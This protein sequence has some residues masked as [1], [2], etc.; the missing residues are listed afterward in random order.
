MRHQVCEKDQTTSC[1]HNGVGWIRG[2]MAL[3]LLQPEEPQA[4]NLLRD[5]WRAL[6]RSAG[7]AYRWG[8][9]DNQKTF[10]ETPQGSAVPES[11]SE[12]GQVSRFS[13]TRLSTTRTRQR[14]QTIKE[15]ESERHRGEGLPVPI[16]CP[17]AKL[18]V[19]GNAVSTDFDYGTSSL[20]SSAA[21]NSTQRRA[22]GA[23]SRGLYG[24]GDAHRCQSCCG[25]GT[26]HTEE[27]GHQR[28]AVSHQ[29][30]GQCLQEAQRGHPSETEAPLAVASAL[31]GVHPAL[32]DSAQQLQETTA[33]TTRGSQASSEG[34][35]CSTAGH[36]RTEC[37]SRDYREEQTFA[38]TPQ[39][40]RHRSG[41]HGRC[42]SRGGE[43]E[44]E[45]PIFAPKK[46]TCSWSRTWLCFPAFGHLW[47]C[48]GGYL[49]RRG[50]SSRLESEEAEICRAQLVSQGS[51]RWCPEENQLHEPTNWKSRW[52]RTEAYDYSLISDDRAASSSTLP[53]A[54][55]R[56]ITEPLLWR[57]SVEDEPDFK[58]PWRALR[59]AWMLRYQVIF[60][61]DQQLQ[62]P[63]SIL[64]WNWRCFGSSL[65]SKSHS[66]KEKKLR[67]D[68]DPC[69]ESDVKS[70]TED[71]DATS[72]MA[73]QPRHHSTPAHS[74]S[75]SEDSDL[76][77]REPTSP[78]SSA[79]A[80]E[81]LWRSVQVY[82]LHS[83]FARGRA[84]VHPVEQ[85][86]TQVRRLLGYT[87]HEVAHI[88]DI[89]PPPEDLDSVH[90]LPMLL[91]AHDDLYYGDH[92]R[93]VL[94]D[95]DLHG[96]SFESL[97][98]TDRYT[99]LI[100]SVVHRAY[101]LRIAG[102]ASYCELQDSRCLVWHRGN[103]LPAQSSNTVT[104]MHG[105]YI[106]I[107]V[108]PFEQPTIPTH[109][110]VRACKAG[111][112]RGQLVHRFQQL[113]ANDD[114]LFT[115]IDAAQP[116]QI[117]ADGDD[118]MLTQLAFKSFSSF[119][120]KQDTAT[121]TEPLLRE[122][123]IQGS[124]HQPPILERRI[125]GALHDPRQV[126]GTDALPTWTA[127][128]H[129]A[130]TAAAAVEI[131]EEG[132]VGFVDTWYLRGAHP[133]VTENTRPYRA[134]Q[135]SQHWFREI[136]DL[137]RDHIDWTIP[138]HFHWV[139]PIPRSLMT[140]DRFGHLIIH[141]DP[142]HDL[143]PN[144]VTI[145]FEGNH[146]STMTFAAVLQFNPI[147]LHA[148]RD[149][150]NLGRHCL[151]RRCALHYDQHT[152]QP[153][154][155]LRVPPGAGLEFNIGP[156]IELYHIHDDHMTGPTLQPTS[157]MTEA[158][159]E[160]AHPP[161]EAHSHFVQALHAAW[162]VLATEGPAGIENVL[163]IQTWY[164]ESGYVRHH[165]L[166]RDVVLGEDFWSWETNIIHR[167]ADF[168]IPDCD[169]D[170]H[171]VTPAPPTAANPN[172]VHVIVAQNLRE[173]ECAS[174]ATTYD[175]AIMRGQPYT[176]ALIFPNAV[177]KGEILRSTGKSFVCPP[178]MPSSTCTCWFG[179][180]Q[181]LDG[182]RFP[183]RNGFSFIVIVHRAIP[184]NFWE[185]DYDGTTEHT[186]VSLLQIKTQLRRGE[187]QI[188][189][190]VAHT[191]QP[192]P[193]SDKTQSID[194]HA[195]ILAF[196][197]FDAH[198]FLPTF[199][200][201]GVPEG[202][203]AYPWLTTWWDY[204][205]HGQ[206]L[207]I[208]YDGSA[209][210]Q[211]SGGSVSAAAAA[212]LRIGTEWVFAGAIATPLPCAQD[213]YA[214]EHFASA[215]SMKLCYDILKI[216]EVIGTPMPEVHFCLDSLTVGHQTAGLWSCFR[217]PTLG[218]A[219]RNI[220]RL[221]ETRFNPTIAHW[222]VRGHSGHPGNELVDLLANQAHE[223][224]PDSSAAWLASISKA[225]FRS[226]SDWFWILFDAEFL[227]YW[228]WHSLRFPMPTTAPSSKLLG[229][230]GRHMEAEKDD[231]GLQ[232]HL[233]LATCNVLSL[234]G[235]RDDTE[236]GIQGPARQEMLLQQLHEE[237]ITI[238][239]LQETRL[240]KLH[241][242]HAEKYFLFRA[243][244]TDKGQCGILVGISK[245]LTFASTTSGPPRQ[246]KFKEEHIS[247]V[248]QSPRLLIL[249]VS[250]PALRCILVAGHAPHSGNSVEELHQWWESVTDA[251][252]Q[253][254]ASWP[255]LLLAD[256]NAV[257][258]H[259]TTSAIGSHQ[260]GPHEI[261]SEA[262]EAFIHR[263]Q[264]WLP[265][266]FEEHQQGPGDTW[267]HSSGKTRRIDYV[268][269]PCI[270]PTTECRAWISDVIDPSIT[271]TD[272][273]AACV[274]VRFQGQLRSPHTRRLHD[275]LVIAD[276]KAVDL[277]SLQDSEVVAPQLDVH[278]HAALL[279]QMIVDAVAPQCKRLPPRPH[280]KSIS[281]ETWQLVL[282]KR[283]ARRHL[284]ELNQ[285]Q[286][287]DTLEILFGAWSRKRP[288]QQQFINDYNRLLSMQD[289]LVA[290]ALSTFRQ[291]GRATAS[292][293]RKD[294][295]RFYQ[296]L[297]AEGADHLAPADVRRFWA[298]I[299]RS[300]PK[301]KQRHA[302]IAPSKIEALEGQ[303]VPHLC[304]LELGSVTDE[305]TLIQGCH[306]RQ[307]A[308]MINLPNDPVP[309]DCLPSL[310]SF[311]SALRSTTPN[312]ATGL[313]PV[314]AGLHHDQ[315]PILARFY[316]ALLLKIHLWCSEPIQF[317]GGVMCL[318]HKKGS[319]DVASNYRGIL[320]L[321]SVAKRI[322]SIMRSSLM[323]TLTPHRAE[324]QLGGFANQMV[325]FGFHSVVSWTR[326]LEARGFSTAV[327]YLDLTSA[328]HHLI[329]EFVLGV[330]NEDDFMMILEELSTAGHP[331][332]ALH[333]GQQL[334]G[335]L[336][337][338]GC[339]YRIL[340]ILQDIHQDTWFTV[341]RAEVVRTKRGTR[342]GSPLADALFHVAMAQII[343]EVRQWIAQDEVFNAVL[344]KFDLPALT[345]VWADD[346][347]VPWTTEEASDLV[348]AVCRLVKHVDDVFTAK[349]FSINYG[350]NKTNVVISFLGKAAP[351]LRTQYLHQQRPGVECDLAHGRTTWLHFKPT[352]KHLGHTYVASQSLDVEMRNRIGQA[353]QA[354]ATIGKPILFNRHL[355]Q[356]VRLRLFRVLVETK[357][358][359][360]LGT[361]RTPTVRQ[362]QTLRT[363]YI[364]MLRRV[365]RIDPTQH[366]TNAKILTQA[367]TLDV[368]VLLALDRLRYARKLFTV[369]PVFLQHLVH[370]EYSATQDSW[371]HGLAADLA[372][373][374]RVIPGS[375][376]FDDT[377]D[378]T[379]AIDYWQ[380]LDL[381]WKKQL[382][383]LE[384]QCK[385][386]EHM[387]ADLTEIHDQFF[388]V[389]HQAGAAFD[390]T[391]QSLFEPK[392]AEVHGCPCGR[393]FTT[394]Q[395]LAL[396]RVR[397]HQQF[398]PEHNFICGA[399]CP[400][401]LRF[402][403][404]SAR[405]Q[406]HLAYIPRGGGVN[407]CF[408]ALTKRGY[409]TEY[410]AAEI[411]QHL[412]GAVRLDA[413]QTPGPFGLIIPVQ[414]REIAAVK[415][416][417]SS[418]EEE[419]TIKAVP[420]NH[421]IAGQELSD[422]LSKCTR[423]WVE[424]FRG[425]Q[426][427]PE[428]ITDLGDWW[429]RLLFTFGEEFEEWTE[430]VFLS[431]GDHILPE[432]IA[433][434]MDGE[435]E[436]SIENAYYE[437]YKILP[438]VECSTRL[439]QA[440][441]KLQ[442]LM[443]EMQENPRP[444][445]H[446]RAGTANEKERRV[447][448]QQITLAFDEQEEWLAALRT[449]QWRDL[450]PEVTTPV[451]AT[452]RDR[453]HFLLVHV[454][455]GR[456]REGDFHSCVADWAARRN[457]TVTVLSMDTANS[458]SMGNLNVK[459][460]SWQELLACYESGLVSATLAGTPCETFSEARHQG[461]DEPAAGD[462]EKRHLPRPLRS[463]DRLLGLP[464]LS[465][466]ELKQLQMGS[467]FFLQGLLLIAHHLRCGGF[468]ISEHPA[469]PVQP[470]RASIWSSPWVEILR[471][472]PEVKLD[473]VPQWKFGAPVPKP[474]G[475][476]SLRLPCILKSLYKHADETLQKP[477]GIA[478]GRNLDGS[479]KTSCLKEYPERFSAGLARAFTDQ[480]DREMQQGRVRPTS[481]VAESMHS[482]IRE[483]C[484]AC[485]QIRQCSSWL[486]D[487]QPGSC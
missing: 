145:N 18:D 408:H 166:M 1:C 401:C 410:Q 370:V 426:D 337:R 71:F 392:R 211:E 421:L 420:E 415:E 139:T 451:Y 313:D 178:H 34:C 165:D 403:W 180:Q 155:L 321:G 275:K 343:T 432:I 436:Y 454:F 324:G 94:I 192:P 472:H 164:L 327:L 200:L 196:E 116:H 106:K 390:P 131:E 221:I 28:P 99:S 8:L 77:R 162:L 58:N 474:T 33:R 471:R 450:P 399:T 340:A 233:R 242:A 40:R 271:K 325:Q 156:P 100:P 260:A 466:R 113:G 27:V 80:G 159:I 101:L 66:K 217:H 23:P 379:D 286:K 68:D 414:E 3:Q 402:F 36:Q 293:L 110:A 103:L 76:D 194:L 259:S 81:A 417:I 163:R 205:T 26:S 123:K 39:C 290:K 273:L 65:A 434:I 149:L 261:K 127:A 118:L 55:P 457:V 14:T 89:N 441:L 135:F 232:L 24:Q 243:K 367:D 20:S 348:P 291:L 220:H 344:R 206:E 245:T 72:L 247:V 311:E 179:G 112:T 78:S 328:F 74:P 376:P 22:L 115:D 295:I 2:W 268:G 251:I 418:L 235:Q 317:K 437:L 362:L 310:T 266:T 320:L 125:A 60:E 126:T 316:Y 479:F 339:D 374:N 377:C 249:R 262:F 44:E 391:Y 84:Q 332:E 161:L 396:H 226:R 11:P 333:Q 102:V 459:S 189:G 153:G 329:R 210:K 218:A 21:G 485:G 52:L 393:S 288:I 187:R 53:G 319:T 212:F 151:D 173:F 425:G 281:E 69:Q 384:R 350:L 440:K 98:E 347:A 209:K 104:V 208:Y 29:R 253:R 308:T 59:N 269:I 453:P 356:E 469:P 119:Q 227:P 448:R 346:V 25:E 137:W 124:E 228:D 422:R 318:I 128:M 167:W 446:V 157:L 199:H 93:A 341:S 265:S 136:V 256:A 248:S 439:E 463:R 465:L 160:I 351:L 172:E 419:L 484:M 429:L 214:A 447:T 182:L 202:H 67:F 468:F 82:D 397:A 487:Y 168:V 48:H 283:E 330:N 10:A 428:H 289:L 314:P 349:G 105:D 449:L 140:R 141:Q 455:A 336:A 270:W 213:S 95:V 285:Q 50:S 303:I 296:A 486:P 216:H 75:S 45:A 427:V 267:S 375:V 413:L 363:A 51:V 357:L 32:A 416:Q 467:A 423:I 46:R 79:R 241:Q 360:G 13:S 117:A 240:R 476:L 387:M 309:A 87:H 322:H 146:R 70:L 335:A 238:F 383:W 373:M 354:M 381:P 85:T 400:Q 475:L 54:S 31:G 204:A 158:P 230:D 443:E 389:L 132:P 43:H 246:F 369:G 198:F 477:S 15:E 331:T 276:T 177:L 460:A 120:S 406:Q 433:E 83:N 481:P 252:P 412:H 445:R 231:R 482:W 41:S 473:V 407:I 301:F 152:L 312:K 19:C 395:G 278:T 62:K 257:V 207:W 461:H 37:A 6:G 185:D 355:P 297:L 338:F 359:Y 73:R 63:T 405:L 183:N 188:A 224:E 96:D 411:P 371:L 272:H 236:C 195:T 176:S 121:A 483:A 444:H 382:R 114:D 12:Q 35:P 4:R 452:L 219:L 306:E 277:T 385:A 64:F 184:A 5:L 92:R 282:R 16:V 464:A 201:S 56:S 409:T 154:E 250:T 388:K 294:D 305:A 169:V 223:L 190:Q 424:R 264:L 326:I 129:D 334:I 358:F 170:F 478:I 191:Q 108:P 258:G 431:W 90:V 225:E 122:C 368:R 398:A 130:F 142:R 254:Y 361:W 315:A 255:L 366:R 435:L 133:L 174:M 372:W 86:F 462:E 186:D 148:L 229:L 279:Q 365:M 302:N 42:R 470:T 458:A 111:L 378:F 144:V 342:P 300:L 298:V 280:K 143:V 404:S 181:L 7:E 380:R 134:D 480:L 304:E 171:L 147:E 287:N 438:R 97:I 394:A 193:S 107:A 47:S 91:I 299:R 234:C 150:L 215:I 442:R 456:R 284:A 353:Q 430:L 61:Q 49:Q 237:Q 9:R 244:A 274:D 307:L 222:H 197:Q 38:Y 345:V 203:S 57:H 323:N 138:I 386:Q 352:Y 292:A 30:P 175:N 263:H 364:S 109:Y 17:S 88:F 239:A